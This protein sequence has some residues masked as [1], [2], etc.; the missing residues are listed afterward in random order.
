MG[1]RAD[2]YIGRG[3]NAEWLG[4]IGWDGYPEAM[5]EPL[6]RADSEESFRKV[7]RFF[8]GSRSDW[9]APEKGWPWPWDDSGTTDFAYAWDEGQVWISRFGRS[10]Q[11]AADYNPDLGDLDFGRKVEFPDMSDRKNV[12]FGPRSGLIVVSSNPEKDP[13]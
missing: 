3:K 8:A 12:T 10:W 5:P 11:S 1:T 9:T 7:L 6:L 13:S 4:S 2:L